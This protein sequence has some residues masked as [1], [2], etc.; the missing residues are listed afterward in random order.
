MQKSLQPT[1][2]DLLSPEVPSFS[3]SWYQG[4]CRL[5]AN[6][7]SD[8]ADSE[9][10]TN[11]G[12]GEKR[13]LPVWMAASPLPRRLRSASDL[14]L[15]LI[16]QIT[17]FP[18]RVEAAGPRGGRGVGPLAVPGSLQGSRMQS[19]VRTPGCWLRWGPLNRGVEQ[20]PKAGRSVRTPSTVAVPP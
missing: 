9:G 15:L 3:S 11:E 12:R 6:S 5:P 19:A 13:S 16:H 17:L 8:E 20:A 1:K 7:A 18:I 14:S 4:V 2:V 10:N